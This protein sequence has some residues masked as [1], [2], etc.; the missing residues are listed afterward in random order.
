MPDNEIYDIFARINTHSETLKNQELRNAKWFGDFKS[1]AYLLANEFVKFMEDNKLF[2]PRQIARMAEVEFVSELLLAMQEGIREG[3]K[4]VIDNAYRT[5]D[6]SLPNRTRHEERFRAT[7]DVIGGIVGDQLSSMRFRATRLFYPLFC[8]VYH[9]KYKLPRLQAPRVQPRTRHFPRYLAAL[10]R[11]DEQVSI[12]E[13]D[14]DLGGETPRATEIRAFVEAYDKHWV[15]ATNRTLLTKFL[16]D[17]F[18][19][20]LK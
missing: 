9:L 6:D 7:M 11:I 15:H 3:K 1:C 5:Y 19:A 17:R 20:T 10:Q 18:L 2:A 16:C 13:A 14:R 8:A 4:T 12:V